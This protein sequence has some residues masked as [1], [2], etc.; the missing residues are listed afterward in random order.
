MTD[1]GFSHGGKVYTPNRTAGI[2][3]Q[4]NADRNAAI[5]RAELTRWAAQPDDALG[6]YTIA[7]AVM[8]QYARAGHPTPAI[9]DPT[10]GTVTTWLGTVIGRITS[11]RVYR[12]NF[13]GR[14]LAITMLGTNGARYYGRASWDHGTVVHLRKSRIA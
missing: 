6:Y 9:L 4:Q 10:H 11:A 2:P 1:Y 14:M 7:P 3:V 13:G 5:E 12:H 8:A